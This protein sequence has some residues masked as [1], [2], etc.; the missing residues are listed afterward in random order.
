MRSERRA[1]SVSAYLAMN[2]VTRARMIT[3]GYGEDQ[4]IADNSVPEGK[5]LN[6]RVEVAIMA[7]D[8]LKNA[9]ERKAGL[10]N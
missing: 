3:I 9:A 10:S 7:N 2:E 1:T 6:R 4:P 8:D 5:A